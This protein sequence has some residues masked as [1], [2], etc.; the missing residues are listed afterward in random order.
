MQAAPPAAM[1]DAQGAVDLVHGM[2]QSVSPAPQALRLTAPPP[3]ATSAADGGTSD[4]GMSSA[5]QQKFQA[6]WSRLK[7]LGLTPAVEAGLQ[8]TGQLQSSTAAAQE[9]Q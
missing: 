5:E 1:Y 7:A 2:L 4:A 9:Q 8:A 3:D 6:V